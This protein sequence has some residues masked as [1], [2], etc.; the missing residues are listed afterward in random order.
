MRQPKD[1]PHDDITIL[2]II[3]AGN[4]V[5]YAIRLGLR[6]VGELP[7][8]P[9]LAVLVRCDPDVMGGELGAPRDD[10][11]GIRE[12]KLRGARD[13]FIRDGLPRDGV[14]LVL[15]CHLDR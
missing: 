11:L 1:I 5:R 4:S 15:V 7:A 9:E 12:D 6:L 8:G 14:R 13:E 10:G 2:D 3:F